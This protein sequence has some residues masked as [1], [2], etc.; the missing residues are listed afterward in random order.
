MFKGKKK[1]LQEEGEESKPQL[2]LWENGC[3]TN[4]S[5]TFLVKKNLLD[6]PMY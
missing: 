6:T 4:Y 3:I 1:P 5:P 2:E